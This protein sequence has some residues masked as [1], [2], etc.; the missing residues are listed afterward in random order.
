MTDITPAAGWV[1]LDCDPNALDQTIRL[2]CMNEDEEACRHLYA[3]G[4]PQDK[5]VR[6]PESCGAGPFARIAHLST[7]EDQN[8]PAHVS[9]KIVRRGSATPQV[10]SLGVDT[11]WLSIDTEN[12]G[13][14]Q[15]RIAGINGELPAGHFHDSGLHSREDGKTWFQSALVKVAK[16]AVALGEQVKDKSFFA[17]EA[18]GLKVE[19]TTK[20]SVKGN[21]G[22]VAS[23]KTGKET[24]D[25]AT[26]YH[27]DA[28]FN[29]IAKVV[30]SEKHSIHLLDVPLGPFTIPGI[31]NFGPKII[32]ERP[33]ELQLTSVSVVGG[34]LNIDHNVIP[35]KYSQDVKDVSSKT[36][37][38]NPRTP[39]ATDIV[40]ITKFKGH[41]TPKIQVGVTAFSHA[42]HA[43][44]S[45]NGRQE[46]VDR[47]YIPPYGIASRELDSSD[48]SVA[49]KTTA[50]FTRSVIINAGVKG[51]ALAFFKALTRLK[52]DVPLGIRAS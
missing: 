6:L 49:A 28:S 7:A 35:Q 13:E 48:G 23:G 36:L 46:I 52:A 31:A 8:I 27:A 11:N 41:L 33:S 14:V 39:A 12:R 18:N 26:L 10:I 32:L 20:G 22:F 40:G 17:S 34:N 44:A 25:M 38:P 50:G 4:G 37:S 16:A 47:V 1:I 2:V 24:D 51:Q 42:M 5:V 29:V 43:S 30:G 3:H 21:I 15:F 45:V 9:P 19:V